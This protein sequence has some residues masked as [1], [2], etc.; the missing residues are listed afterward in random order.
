MYINSVFVFVLSGVMVKVVF[1]VCDLRCLMYVFSVLW[2]LL[3]CIVD[4]PYE[5]V[6]IGKALSSFAPGKYVMVIFPW[7]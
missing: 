5:C 3:L 4:C 6:M 1:V 7:L 2:L